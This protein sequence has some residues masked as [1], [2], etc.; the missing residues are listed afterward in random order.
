MQP[1][2]IYQGLEEDPD[3]AM[4]IVGKIIRDAQVFGLIDE[5]ETC[6]GWRMAAIQDLYDKVA[7]AWE[8]YIGLPSNLPDDLKEKHQRIYSVAIQRAKSMG[9][10]PEKDLIG[11]K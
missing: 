3:G 6:A 7:E 2:K 11:D 1:D 9:W 10:D 8:P 4:D 5:T